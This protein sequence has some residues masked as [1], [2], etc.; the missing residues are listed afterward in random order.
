MLTV[1]HIDDLCLIR[2]PATIAEYL[3]TECRDRVSAFSVDVK[4]LYYSLPHESVSDEVSNC[5]ERFRCTKF[6]NI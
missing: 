4:D 1:L 6:Q 3:W 2:S 5:I